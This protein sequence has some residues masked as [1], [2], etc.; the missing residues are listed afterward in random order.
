MVAP[1]CG[2]ARVG[3]FYCSSGLTIET[4]SATGRRPLPELLAC[5]KS[6]FDSIDEEVQQ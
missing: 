6:R 1:A 4:K 2:F 5:L 3:F